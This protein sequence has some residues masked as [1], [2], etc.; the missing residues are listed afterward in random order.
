MEE[1]VDETRKFEIVENFLTGIKENFDKKSTKVK[2]LRLLKQG[3]KIVEE[4][5]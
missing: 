5:I 1:L 3:E 2:E 4:Y